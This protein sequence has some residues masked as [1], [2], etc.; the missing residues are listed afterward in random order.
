MIK[1]NNLFG[2]AI[3]RYKSQK[4]V[5]RSARDEIINAFVE[6]INNERKSTGLKPLNPRVIAVLINKNPFLANSVSECWNLYNECKKNGNYKKFWWV[7]K[8]KKPV[9]NS[10]D[11]IF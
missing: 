6:G 2:D 1:T 8:P 9:D 7:V 3:D 4:K 10:V 11:D 5:A